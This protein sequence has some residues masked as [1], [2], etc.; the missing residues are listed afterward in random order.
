MS[1]ICVFNLQRARGEGQRVILKGFVHRGS[2]TQ[3]CWHFTEARASIVCCMDLG[4][5][6]LLHSRLW[7]RNCVRAYRYSIVSRHRVPVDPE[8]H[9]A[10]VSYIASMKKIFYLV[11]AFIFY[12]IAQTVITFNLSN[13]SDDIKKLS[14]RIGV[15]S[16]YLFPA[17]WIL[18]L[19]LLK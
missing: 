10:K 2:A 15:H 4:F 6:Y 7:N 5:H 12:A 16:R 18:L 1:I 14:H 9:S 19:L 8:W 17:L 13:P 3:S 11:Y